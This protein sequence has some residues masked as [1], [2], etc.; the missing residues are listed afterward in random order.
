M[1]TLPSLLAALSL[2]SCQSAPEAPMVWSAAERPAIHAPDRRGVASLNVHDDDGSLVVVVRNGSE[3]TAVLDGE[4]VPEERIV[5]DGDRV[6]IRSA[7]GTVTRVLRLLDGGGL[8]YPYD[9][10]IAI[11]RQAPMPAG[12]PRKIIGVTSSPVEPQLAAQLGLEPGQAI[13]INSVT[14]GLPA[15]KAGLKQHDVVLRLDG[16]GPVTSGQLGETIQAREPGDV[17]TL[18]V[19]RAG[20]P[21]EI[22]VTIEKP[23][24]GGAAWVYTVGQTAPSAEW[25]GLDAEFMQAWRMGQE[26]RVQTDLARAEFDRARVELERAHELLA[27]Q[28]EELAASTDALDPAAASL[29]ADRLRATVERLAA[30]ER[31]LPQAHD[32]VGLFRF[33]DG[34]NALVVPRGYSVAAPAPPAPP[35]PPAAPAA[36][37]DARLTRLEERLAR[38]EEL[39]TKLVGAPSDDE[40][41]SP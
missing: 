26:A 24:E 36:L 32:D 22:P 30:I 1:T 15:D 18:S 5:R 19:L 8:A 4:V 9:A 40:A 10:E 14:P 34:K 38:L 17:L 16:L 39:L 23:R 11:A 13:V 27:R 3:I 33:G 25:S 6:S 31:E 12:P 35:T 37:S 2:L 21:M 28:A 7:D 41:D 20:S 29:H